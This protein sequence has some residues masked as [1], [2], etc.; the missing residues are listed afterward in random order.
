MFYILHPTLLSQLDE[1]ISWCVCGGG[2]GGGICEGVSVPLSYQT[3]IS[4]RR[5][6]KDQ[7]P[8]KML[9]NVMLICSLFLLDY[10]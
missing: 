1:V 6:F 7:G 4:H 8:V 10:H 5:V 9:E 3:S 2:G